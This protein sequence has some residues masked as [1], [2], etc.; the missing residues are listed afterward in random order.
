MELNEFQQAIEDFNQ[1]IRLTPTEFNAYALLGTAYLRLGEHKSAVDNFTVAIQ[2][3]PD[4][5]AYEGRASAYTALRQFDLAIVDLAEL[6]KL[7]PSEARFHDSRAELLQQIGSSGEAESE[8]RTALKLKA[9]DHR[10]MNNLGYMFAERNTR[11]DEARDLVLQALTL[12]PGNG[13]YLDS[14]GWI[15]YR[16]GK[17]SEAE[18]YL[19]MAVA[20]TPGSI[21]EDHLGDV[22]WAQERKR[23]AI[24]QWQVA[25][26]ALAPVE[27]SPDVGRLQKKIKLGLTPPGNINAPTGVAKQKLWLDQSTVEFGQ[28]CKLAWQFTSGNGFLSGIGKVDSSGSTV[29]KPEFSTTYTLLVWNGD[30]VEDTS[31]TVTVVGA[32]GDSS[33]FPDISDFTEPGVSGKSASADYLEFLGF[34]H[35]KL[36]DEF[37]FRVK[38][39]FL[40]GRPWS[41]LYTNRQIRD[42]LVRLTDRGVRHRRIAYYVRIDQLPRGKLSHFEVRTLLQYQLFGESTWRPE[43]PEIDAQIGHAA[44]EE[45]RN[46]LQGK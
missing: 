25:L 17:L 9:D 42:K 44:A 6:C 13:A 15:Y 11:L 37:A 21:E 28:P 7:E 5:L 36:Q 24:D 35:R 31:V 22:Y 27:G 20:Q 26:K 4:P 2:R 34:V 46:T 41:V 18:H 38:G 16:M 32:K 39:D 8:Y 3:G 45:L 23:E 19:K 30:V 40:P 43:I 14:L 10:A 12:Q 33:Q 29:V 1:E